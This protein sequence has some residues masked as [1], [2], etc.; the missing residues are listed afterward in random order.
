MEELTREAAA[1]TIS[2]QR[3][4]TILECDAEDLEEDIYRDTQPAGQ[5][6]QLEKVERFEQR[7]EEER[8][9][10]RNEEARFE[11]RNE[12]KGF[13]VTLSDILMTDLHTARETEEKN[14]ACKENTLSD[15]PE[16][17]SDVTCYKS[18]S[19][20]EQCVLGCRVLMTTSLLSLVILASTLCWTAH[21]Q[22]LTKQLVRTGAG[23]G[24]VHT[25]QKI[26]EPRQSREKFTERE[27]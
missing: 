13:E 26:Q 19:R 25:E 9:D 1:R 17:M 10:Q 8:F 16:L 6:E 24:S 22:L 27:F 20:R 15:E 4:E 5:D 21:P 18:R 3:L 12:E 7:N 2:E 14:E 23:A 11:K